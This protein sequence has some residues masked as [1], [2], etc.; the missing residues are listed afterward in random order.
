MPMSSR[1]KSIRLR[2]ALL[3]CGLSGALLALA[4]P[5]P[6]WWPLAWV[7]LAPW[8]VA[9]RLGSGWGA[10]LGSWLGGFAFFGVL[11]Y[12]L[13]L[14]G[15]S[16][17]F[18]ACAILG[19]ALLV[20]GLGVRWMGRLG[21]LARIIGAAALWCGVEWVRGLGEFGFTWG[22]LGY[23]QSPALWLLPVA[24]LTGT[25]GISFLIVLVNAAIGEAVVSAGRRE[26]VGRAAVR[27][28]AACAFSAVVV[29]GAHRW[30]ARQR[31]TGAPVVVSVVQGSASGPLRAEDVNV[32]LSVEE[33]AA[34]RRIYTELTAEAARERPVLVVWPESVLTSDP[35]ADPAVAEWVARSARLAHA[36]LLAGGPYVGKRGRHFNSAYLYAASGNQVAHYDKVQLVPFGEYVPWRRHLPFVER[37]HVRN[38]DFAAGPMHR[39][40]QAGIVAIGPMICFESIFPQISWQL[41][42]RGA[43]VLVIITNDAWFGHTAAAAQHRQIAVLRAVEANRWVLR[44]ASAGIS[45]IISPEGR[46]VAEAGLFERKALSHEIRLGPA[47]ARPRPLGMAFAWLMVFLSVA[48]LIA[49]AALPRRGRPARAARPSSRPRPPGRAAPR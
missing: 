10:V 27:V 22:W 35:D 7:A 3:L 32:P 9:V 43:Q 25:I 30:T 16:V 28:I 12:W 47:G 17:W 29:F 44:A 34:T 45:S 2:G 4:F 11:C 36:W 18:L 39:V 24:R 13:G 37:Y 49:P 6:G 31:L 42:A 48:F 21:A 14:F 33:R 20:W 23:S 26:P 8:F 15:V 38:V 41:T 5:R 1:A 19:F 46:I 40:L